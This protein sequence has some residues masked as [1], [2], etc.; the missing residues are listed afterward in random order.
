[1]FVT[2]CHWMKDSHPSLADLEA[3]FNEDETSVCSRLLFS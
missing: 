2:L 3:K 1:M